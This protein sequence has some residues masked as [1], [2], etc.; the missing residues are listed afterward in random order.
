MEYHLSFFPCGLDNE[1]AVIEDPA[2]YAEIADDILDVLEP[3]GHAALA[4]DP[5]F[6]DKPEIREIEP[7]VLPVKIEDGTE[8]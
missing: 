2:G 4:D 6:L 5:A 1:R 3:D 8:E 7:A